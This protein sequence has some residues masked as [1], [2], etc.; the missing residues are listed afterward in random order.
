[1]SRPGPNLDEEYSQIEERMIEESH[2]RNTKVL[3]GSF[4]MILK[5][6]L[7]F[8]KVFPKDYKKVLADVRHK[9]VSKN[10]NF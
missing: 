1:M 6:N 9:Q 10:N 7:S 5:T 8:I 2:Y 4:L 3:L